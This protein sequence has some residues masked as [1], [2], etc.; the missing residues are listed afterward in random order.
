[1]GVPDQNMTFKLQLKVHIMLKITKKLHF[2]VY[3]QFAL[4][5]I[6]PNKA[7]SH[8]FNLKSGENSSL[9]QLHVV[10]LTLRIRI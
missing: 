6:T 5:K 9:K 1:M 7:L 10:I 4:G 3:S 8:N 2:G